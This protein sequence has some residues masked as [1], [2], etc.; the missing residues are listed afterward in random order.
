MADSNSSESTE[1]YRRVAAWQLTSGE[2][3]QPALDPSLPVNSYIICDTQR[4]GSHM[5]GRLLLNAGIGLPLEYFN[6]AMNVEMRTRWNVPDGDHDTYV[7]EVLARRTAPNGTWGCLLQLPHYAQ[8][9]Q[10]ID[11]HLLPHA[12]LIY[13]Y[14]RDLVSQA[15]SLHLAGR[16]GL[17]SF[18][19][20]KTT[21]PRVDSH[22]APRKVGSIFHTLKCAGKLKREFAQWEQFFACRQAKVLRIAYEDI[23]ADQSAAIR[24]IAEYLNLPPTAYRIPPAEQRD[25]K[26]PPEVEAARQRLKRRS[27]LLGFMVAVRYGRSR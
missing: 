12:K 27:K 20:I 26:M 5:L 15:I 7:R 18:D 10:A 11:R 4:S 9:H 6:I 22:G 13:L 24:Q 21:Q 2:Y 19:G 14:R 16:T 23:L 25:N 1:Q 3:D 17:W 8:H